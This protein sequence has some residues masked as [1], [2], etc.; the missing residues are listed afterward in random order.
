MA[1]RHAASQGSDTSM[2]KT[3]IP[4]A[5]A[6]LSHHN[7]DI[8]ALEEFRF[9][10]EEGFLRETRERFKG[11]ILLQT[12]NRVEVLVQG[13]AADLEEYLAKLGRTGCHLLEGTE[14][15]RH[16]LEMA[17]GLDSMIVG[18][19][20]ILG[21]L[22]QALTVSME[23]GTCSRILEQCITKAIHVGVQVRRRT[24]INKGAVSI[25][26]AAVEM[27]ESMIGSL[28]KRHILVIGSGEIGSLVAK[29]LAARDL[30]A[31]YVAN[32][33]YSQAVALAKKIDGRAVD[34]ADL[35]HYIT[36]SDV[37]ISCTAAPHAVIRHDRL[38]E[39]ISE[40]RWPHEEPRPLVLIDIAQPRD[41]EEE[42]RTID[43]VHLYTIDNLRTVSETNLN[44][45][46]IEADRARE[47]IG[48][49][50]EQFTRLLRQ[51]AS[52]ETIG[53][54]YNWAEGIRVRERDRAFNRIGTDDGRTLQII[55]DLTKVLVK[56]MLSD[57][58][59][60]VR[61]CAEY[62]DLEAADSFVNALTKGERPC[63][64]KEE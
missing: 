44:T 31:I 10:D 21:Q 8:V 23:A 22:K 51:T 39:A 9:E 56:K 36:L 13:D 28:E 4:L 64:R 14:V 37:V 17:A 29:A 2:N 58:T 61:S 40:S 33:T 41:I 60:S 11:V 57:A 27:A 62:G 20:Q 7:A 50:L 24:N 32:R 38:S 19:D 30:T 45:R 18:E 49:E 43:G 6:S 46:L 12:C 16:L 59:V 5:L 53:A 1:G 47:Y 34:F 52:D 25:G 15:L 26:S 3:Q 63:F 35:Y 54:L 55:D 42:V 48:D